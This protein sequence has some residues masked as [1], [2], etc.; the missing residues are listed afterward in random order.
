M[1]F[2]LVLFGVGLE[3]ALATYVVVLALSER[4][5]LRTLVA[6]AG[7]DLSAAVDELP[8]PYRKVAR[9]LADA[10]AMEQDFDE[11]LLEALVDVTRQP[12][13]KP[14]GM[15]L[16]VGAVCSLA[17]LAPA[18]YGMIATA[19]QVVT[20]W[21]EAQVLDAALVALRAQTDLETPFALLREA[22]RGSALLFFGL[23][24]VWALAWYLR[25]PEV[26]EARFIRALLEA[27][28]RASPRSAAP[29]SGRLAELIA[30][31]RSLGRPITA[32]VVCLVGV[33]AGWFVLY[34]TAGFRAANDRQPVYSVWPAQREVTVPVEIRL[35]SSRAGAPLA[36]PPP[37]SL[38]IGQDKAMLGGAL[39]VDL[40]DGKLPEGWR[41]SASELPNEIKGAPLVLIAHEE[42]ALDPVLDLISFLHRRDRIRRVDVIVARSVATGTPGGR[43]VQAAIPIDIGG[44]GTIGLELT[45]EENGIRLAPDRTP[46]PYDQNLWRD[47]LRRLV[48][49]N[50]A[51]LRDAD[52]ARVKIRIA[53]SGLEYR[54]FVEVLSAADTACVGTID[55]GLPGLGLEF[56]ISPAE[57]SP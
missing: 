12:V 3:L 15:R 36:E 48:R 55:C 40:T 42:L 35:P 43:K 21:N 24:F 18:S 27:G 39:L 9:R 31:D 1:V 32:L 17:L 37:P 10:L 53:S 8:E 38:R 7:E 49:S 6:R 57:P 23:A 5:M 52:R 54:R 19:S 56:T 16:M 4:R 29:V 22:F 20:T 33:T 34:R 28:A 14:L 25:R 44:E 46:A 26:R 45:L 47:E 2:L 51:L 30:P 11:A 41:Q 13:K 50:S